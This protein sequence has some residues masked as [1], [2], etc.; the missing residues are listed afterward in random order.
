MNLTTILEPGDVLLYRGTGVFSRLIQV[1]TWSKVSHCEGYVG[2][3]QSVA[4]RDGKGVGLYPLRVE[5]LCAIL[6]PRG[7]FNLVVAMDWFKT[8]DKQGYDWFGLLAFFAARWQGSTN[9]KMFCS[10][11]L[12]RWQRKG[13]IEPFSPEYDA[14]AV[15]PGMFL[16][17]PVY[18]RIP[19]D[20]S[21]KKAA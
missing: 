3:G 5:G 7:L 4:S 10:E 8:V 19:L 13:D 17:S 6:R 9:Q 21:E 16:S 2:Q 18:T 20:A 11:F 1:K 12:T 15:S 14:D